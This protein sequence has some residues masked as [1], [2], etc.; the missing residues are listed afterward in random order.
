MSAADDRNA[1]EA[2]RARDAQAV[3]P[4]PYPSTRQER[5]E[6][7]CPA[8]NGCCTRCGE[9]IRGQAFNV[10][11]QHLCGLCYEDTR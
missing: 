9:R 2:C 7:E 8:D 3:R 11:R 4:R 10:Y 6:I 5:Q 1:A